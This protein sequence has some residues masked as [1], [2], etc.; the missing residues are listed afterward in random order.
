MPN[1]ITN[2]VPDHHIRSSHYDS[3]DEDVVM[4]TGTVN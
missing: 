2:M 4:H 1:S 3:Y